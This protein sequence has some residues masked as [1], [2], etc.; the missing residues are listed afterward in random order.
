MRAKKLCSTC[1]KLV[2]AGTSRCAE[3]SRAAD[4]ARG[5]FNQR[6]YGGP[7]WNRARKVCLDRDTVCVVCRAQP[8]NV[9]DHFP[10]GRAELV[11]AGVPDPDAP[12]R[13]R[14]LCRS[15]HSKET[16]QRQPGGWNAR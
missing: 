8:A 3:C 5:N 2:P 7:A 6:G 10:T 4:R 16:A 12:H 13:L 11:T 15:C 1:K 14:G 9:A